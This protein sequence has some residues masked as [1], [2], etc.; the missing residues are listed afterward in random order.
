MLSDTRSRPRYAARLKARE[1]WADRSVDVKIMS[2]DHLSNRANFSQPGFAG[3][4][5]QFVGQNDFPCRFALSLSQV[6]LQELFAKQILNLKTNP[7]S[8]MAGFIALV[9]FVSVLSG[10]STG[11]AL[12]FA[13]PDQDAF[14]TARGNAFVA[15]GDD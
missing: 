15:T 7:K 2:R 1:E 3:G 8:R 12:G 4:P 14:A 13:L 6:S 5:T 11:F 10:R 9:S